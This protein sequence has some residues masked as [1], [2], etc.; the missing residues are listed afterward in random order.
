MSLSGLNEVIGHYFTLQD[1]K[2]QA[3]GFNFKVGDDVCE[4]VLSGK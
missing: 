2:E 3:G 1:L 4:E